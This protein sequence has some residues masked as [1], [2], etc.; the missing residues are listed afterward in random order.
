MIYVTSDTHFSHEL[1]LS[2]DIGRPKNYEE[3]ISK[4]FKKLR[5][6]DILIHLGDICIGR[7]AEN[8]KRYIEPLGCKKI[9][10][11]GN[12]DKKSNNWYLNHGWSFVCEAF[13]MKFNGKR[14]IFSHE[15]LPW[16]GRCDLN[17]HGHL[18]NCG[19]REVKTLAYNK[20]ISLEQM[21]YSPI[22]LNSIIK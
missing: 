10:V 17:I 11:K 5:D 19:H 7:D 8:H 12:H 1:M 16:D 3:K 13:E 18:H 6:D 15:P 14:I 4:G 21:G 22:S 2:P 20:L 9:L